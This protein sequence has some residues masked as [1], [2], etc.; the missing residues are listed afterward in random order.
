MESDSA[1]NY[2]YQYF[3]EDLTEWRIKKELYEKRENGISER[4]VLAR[5]MASWI[6]WEPCADKLIKRVRELAGE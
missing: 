3:L 1:F 4:Y 2:C 5:Y 6:L